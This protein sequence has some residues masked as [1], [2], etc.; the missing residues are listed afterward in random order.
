[1][2]SVG[3]AGAGPIVT[4]HALAARTLEVPI[5]AVAS[6]DGHA[7]RERAEQLGVEAC[8][9]ED[10][11]SRADVVFVTVTPAQRARRALA[12]MRAGRATIVEAPMCTTLSDADAMV[13]AAATSGSTLAYAENLAFAPAIDRAVRI[14]RG[15]GAL[16]HLEIRA[17]QERPRPDGH[18]DEGWPGG[19]GWRG[20]AAFD[21]GAHLIGV[22]L[23]VAAPA[24]IVSVAARL[25]PGASGPLDESAELLLGFDDGLSARLEASRLPSTPLWD[26]QAAS[27]VGVVRVELLPGL[28]VEHNGDPVSLPAPRTPASPQL[29]QLGYL[30]QLDAFTADAAAGRAPAL[31]SGFG[32]EVLEVVF[33][34]YRSAERGGARIAL[35]FDGPRD[36]TPGASWT[37]T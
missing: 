29:H 11:T 36:V 22:A 7:A 8:T 20:G 24:R 6:D 16:T 4:V 1:V 18:G 9:F 15:L 23:L 13:A 28:V 3:F 5:A 19:E 21:P 35:P 27:D 2:T 26:L 34:A 12:S 25:E 33:A 37:P 14:R 32:R 30:D 17:H 31:D 10:L